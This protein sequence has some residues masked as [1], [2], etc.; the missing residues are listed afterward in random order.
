[1][2]PRTATTRRTPLAVGAAGAGL[3]DGHE[4]LDLA[5]ALGCQEA[6]DEDVRVGEVELL[7]GV[8]AQSG[9]RRQ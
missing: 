7:G 9:L 4:V 5:H 1:M 6:R 3:P 2:L 8:T